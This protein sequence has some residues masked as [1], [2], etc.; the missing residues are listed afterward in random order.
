MAHGLVGQ[1]PLT[2][3]GQRVGEHEL[4]HSFGEPSGEPELDP[5]AEGMPEQGHLVE[6][7]A[8]EGGREPIEHIVKPPRS[9]ETEEVGD[10]H[11]ALWR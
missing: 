9:P 5:T 6:T 2:R 7:E 8:V 3:H 11:T 4:R 1:S 10:D